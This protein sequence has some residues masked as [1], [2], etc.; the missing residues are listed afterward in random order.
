MATYI[1]TAILGATQGLTEF[2]P[3]SSSGHLILIREIF[4]FQDQ[5][6]AFDAV[7]HLATALA[8]LIYFWQEWKNISVAIFSKKET[9]T[10]TQSRRLFLLI[11]VTTIPAIG[12]ALLWAETIEQQVRGVIPVAALMVFTGLMFIWL[13]RISQAKKD[14]SKLNFFDAL[15]IGLAQAVAIL[16]GISRSGATIITGMYYGLKRETAA[17]YSFLAAMPIIVLAGLYSLWQFSTAADTVAWEA[18]AI[19]FVTAFGFGLLAIH[20]LINFLKN[21]RLFIF[22]GYLIATGAGLIALYLFR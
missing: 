11:V 1:E 22:A 21:N 20:L 7:L 8:V 6:L 19:G 5:G 9:R 3:I 13:E 4:G 2:I 14:T 12:A 10:A 17:R 15:G 16:P 18:L